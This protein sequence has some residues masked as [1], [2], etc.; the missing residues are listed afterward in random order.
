MYYLFTLNFSP[1]YINKF[2]MPNTHF[3]D[4]LN[5]NFIYTD[6]PTVNYFQQRLMITIFIVQNL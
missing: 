4:I 3:F 2:D 6:S 1:L 5:N